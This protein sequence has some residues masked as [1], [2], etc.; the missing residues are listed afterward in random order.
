M[1]AIK[2]QKGQ[3]LVEFAIILPIILLLLMG[4]VEFG[5][6]LNSYLTIQNVAREGARLGIVG[7]SDLEIET[8]IK[9]IS[10]NLTPADIAVKIVPMEGSRKSGDTLKVSVTY[11]Y[12]MTV[13]IISALFNNVIV[14]KAQSSMRLE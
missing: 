11:N 2:N 7:G 12:H 8:L 14:L 13:P 3:S 5:M 10:P 1:N 4:I 6:M 9:S